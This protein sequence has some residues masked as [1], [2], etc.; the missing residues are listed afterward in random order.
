MGIFTFLAARIHYRKLPCHMVPSADAPR[1]QLSLL[2]QWKKAHSSG[3]SFSASLEL[4]LFIY[5]FGHSDFKVSQICSKIWNVS[6]SY[7]RL[8]RP[9]LRTLCLYHCVW[10]RSR[11]EIPEEYHGDT[12]SSFPLKIHLLVPRYKYEQK[13]IV[14]TACLRGEFTERMK[15]NLTEGKYRKY[16]RLCGNW[17]VA[18]QVPSLSL[19]RIPLSLVCAT[20]YLSVSSF[21][22][23]IRSAR[24]SVLFLHNCGIYL[25]LVYPILHDNPQQQS[26]LWF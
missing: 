10:H 7:L 3:S 6:N 18:R 5:F 22:K 8:R 14:R 12:V 2:E 9:T 21:Q 19:F 23:Y 20:F 13:G 16:P 26:F 1:E 17:E 4:Y 15:R 25:T 11:K 24:C